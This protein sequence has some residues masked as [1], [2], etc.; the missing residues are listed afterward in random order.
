M[1]GEKL[2][3][4]RSKNGLTQIAFAEIFNISSGTIA[5]WETG[6]RTPDIEMIKRIAEYFGVSVD[7]LVGHEM[8]NNNI[9]LQADNSTEQDEALILLNRNAKKLSP[10]KRQQLLEMAKLMFKEEFND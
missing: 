7:Y 1:L 8:P 5:M 4:L 6:K 10:E 9:E 2:K 3:E